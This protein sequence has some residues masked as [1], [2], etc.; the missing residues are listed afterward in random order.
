M[1]GRKQF[2][3]RLFH[4]LSLEAMVP[5]DHRLRR[6]E[7]VLDLSF[8]KKLCSA[9][10]SPAGQPSIDPVVLFKMMLLGYLYGMTSERRLAEECSLHLAFRGYLGYDLDEATPDHSVLSKAQIRYG[11]EVFEAFF[12]RVLERCLEAGLVGGKKLF[13]DS[14]LVA[15]NASMKSLVAR[16]PVFQPPRTPGEH[17]DQVFAENPGTSDRAREGISTPPTTSASAPEAVARIPSAD[18]TAVGETIVPHCSRFWA[19]GEHLTAASQ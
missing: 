19:I 18:S 5:A 10:Y 4:T 9:Y 17:L 7:A 12:Q 1:M 16:E 2:V 3:P 15:A 14:T 6:L 8:V 13:A 11:S